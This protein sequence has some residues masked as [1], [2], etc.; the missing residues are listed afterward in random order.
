MREWNAARAVRRRAA[1]GEHLGLRSEA[2]LYRM[3]ALLNEATSQHVTSHLA[4]H[5]HQLVP[6][7]ATGPGGS[8]QLSSPGLGPAWGASCGRKSKSA[9]KFEVRK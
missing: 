5:F 4:S 1:A 8:D 3:K 2:A 9:E 6:C 7:L